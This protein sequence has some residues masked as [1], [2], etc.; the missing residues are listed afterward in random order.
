[1]QAIQEATREVIRGDTR[2]ATKG[3][4]RAATK[5]NTRVVTITK[6]AIASCLYSVGLLLKPLTGM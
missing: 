5:G 2:A 6:P 1:M 4:T 3:D